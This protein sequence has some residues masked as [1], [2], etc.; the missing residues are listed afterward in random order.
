[1]ARGPRRDVCARESCA[2]A[3]SGE[4]I[5]SALVQGKIFPKPAVPHNAVA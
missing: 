1:M 2:T 4:G 3:A 5:C